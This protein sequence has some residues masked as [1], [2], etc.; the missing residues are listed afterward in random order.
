M[1]KPA[2]AIKSLQAVVETN[3]FFWKKKKKVPSQHGRLRV[4]WR[5]RVGCGGPIMG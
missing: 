5:T 1:T 3:E 4:F 2:Q